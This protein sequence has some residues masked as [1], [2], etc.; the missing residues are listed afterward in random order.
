[1]LALRRGVVLSAGDPSKPMQELEVRLGGERRPA[2]ADV[3][4]VGPAHN[5]DEVVVNVAALD[6]ELG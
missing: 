4:L 5:G 6:L 3:A 1:M 2:L